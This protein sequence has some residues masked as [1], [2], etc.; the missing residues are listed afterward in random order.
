MPNSSKKSTH[1]SAK[2][3]KAATLSA[4][5]NASSNEAPVMQPVNQLRTGMPSLDSIVDV[6]P[7]VAA[8]GGAG[9]ASEAFEGA[10][11]YRII[12]TNEVDDYE[13]A[14]ALGVGLDAFLEA[15]SAAAGGNAFKGTARKAAK[16]GIAKAKLETFKDLKDLIKSLT[17]DND[18]RNHVPKITTG[19]TS[20]RVAEEKRN[21]RVRAFLYA[22][23]REEDNDFHLIIG[24]DPEAS[25][26]MYMT[27]E[28]SGLPPSSS[29]SFK[30]LKA[31]RASYQTFFQDNLPGFGYEYPDPP[32]P[33]EIEGSLFFDMSHAKGSAPG[34]KS[35]K[36]RMPT[37]WEVHPITK[38]VFEP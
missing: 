11:K 5:M 36:S 9:A 30:K 12:V 6:K 37:I 35:L 15:K 38:I 28:I 13:E 20:D 19:A 4:A 24:R 7:L 17:P 31:A 21:I 8:G 23:S 34:P 2:K 32:V 16:L 33:V 18:M 10:A 29:A 14:P 1:K 25:K 26:E 3:K 22:A 27:M